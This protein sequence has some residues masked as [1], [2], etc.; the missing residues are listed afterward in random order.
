MPKII[1]IVN[2]F[3]NYYFTRCYIMILVQERFNSSNIFIV[4]YR[5]KLGKL[6]FSYLR[7]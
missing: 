7:K 6:Y 5:V 4:V 3:N 2:K 1:I